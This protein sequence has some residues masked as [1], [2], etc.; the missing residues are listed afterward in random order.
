MKLK[1]ELEP[2]LDIA[3]KIYDIVLSVLENYQELVFQQGDINNNEYHKIQLQLEQMTNKDLSSYNLYEAWE[4]EGLEVL[5]FKISLPD[6]VKIHPITKSDIHQIVTRLVNYS[7]PDM[8]PFAQ[9][10]RYHLS[11]Y[12]HKLLHLNL[13]N[14]KYKYFLRQKDGRDYSID[15]IVDK[16][17]NVS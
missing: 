15:E 1:S 6:P 11:D 4:E 7:S 2:K 3:E 14:Y 5:A 8:T 10:F 16:I 13:P 17:Y 9:S 12:Y